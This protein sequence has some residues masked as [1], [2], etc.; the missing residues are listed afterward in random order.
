[1]R[2]FVNEEIILIMIWSYLLRFPATLRCSLSPFLYTSS[3]IFLVN[4]I[5]NLLFFT[6][7]YFV[8]LPVCFKVYL[9]KFCISIFFTRSDWLLKFVYRAASVQVGDI[10]G[11]GPISV[12]WPRL[13]NIDLTEKVLPN[14]T[15]I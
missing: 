5:G 11:L 6:L 3:Q 4:P 1:M 10:A 7:L 14:I 8:Q 2:L 15:M 12:S 9:F 13:V